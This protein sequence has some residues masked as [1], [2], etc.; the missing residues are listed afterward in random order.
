[1]KFKEI[2]EKVSPNKYTFEVLCDLNFFNEYLKPRGFSYDGTYEKARFETASHQA[3]LRMRRFLKYLS[4]KAIP[5][6]IKD[7]SKVPYEFQ[8]TT[9][10]W[11]P[12]RTE[13]KSPSRRK[14]KLKDVLR[15][16]AA[17]PKGSRRESE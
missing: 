5:E 8:P 2:S 12:I 15:M 16:E 11:T 6:K 10:T 3:F 4:L 1:M 17:E 13:D 14:T 7:L 9:V